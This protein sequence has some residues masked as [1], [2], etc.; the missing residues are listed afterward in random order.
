M[1]KN[2]RRPRG[3]TLI[4]LLVV[5]LII[6]ILAS[7]AIPQYAKIV[8]KGR[9]AEAF[10]CA[11]AIKSAQERYYLKMNSYTTAPD[12]TCVLKN[13]TSTVA[14]GATTWSISFTR[15]NSNSGFAPVYGGYTFSFSDTNG[16]VPTMGG[17]NVAAVGTD[18][19]P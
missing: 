17:A 7:V 6:G 8:E 15:I 11:D 18:L 13:Y 3:F 2:N 14:A 19:L 12:L 5:V 9:I 4:E 10:A 1:T 16:Q